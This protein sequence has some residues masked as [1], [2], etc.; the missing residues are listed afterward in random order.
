M[1]I[2]N[3]KRIF[4]MYCA[5]DCRKIINNLVNY[6]SLQNRRKNITFAQLLQR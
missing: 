5:N 2:Y 1:Q 3:I 6:L 4:Q